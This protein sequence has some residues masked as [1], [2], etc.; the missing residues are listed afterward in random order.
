MRVQSGKIRRSTCKD[1][2]L[3]EAFG[4]GPGKLDILQVWCWQAGLAFGALQADLT[5]SE[6][7]NGWHSSWC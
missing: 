7:C 3:K 1:L 4:T 2:M 5:R 6:L